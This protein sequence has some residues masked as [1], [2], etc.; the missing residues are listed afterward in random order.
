MKTYIT[1]A[2]LLLFGVANAQRY[3]YDDIYFDPVKDAVKVDPVEVEPA[4]PEATN[5]AVVAQ[6]NYATQNIGSVGTY[7]ERLQR[8]HLDAD[9]GLAIEGLS[10]YIGDSNYVNIFMLG[11]GSYNVS[12][13]GDQIDITPTDNYGS[14]YAWESSYGDSWWNR[15]FDAGYLWGSSRYWWNSY[16]Y[17]PFM[18]H[19]SYYHYGYYGHYGH[20]CGHW[21]NYYYPGYIPQSWWRHGYYGHHNGGHYYAHKNNTERDRRNVNSRN[22]GYTGGSTITRRGTTTTS[23][24]DGSTTTRGDG[25]TLARRNGAVSFEGTTTKV[26]TGDRVTTTG[27]GTGTT[28]TNKRRVDKTLP[29]IPVGHDAKIVR[30]NAD[31]RNAAQGNSST[32]SSTSNR[33]SS[34]STSTV[35]R[36]SS[37]VQRGNS[38]SNRG[39]SNATS[40][41]RGSSNNNKSKYIHPTST[42]S[43]KSS[44]SYQGT[45]STSRSTYR[46]TT[47]RT[48]GS[49]RSSGTV[50]SSGSTRSSGAVRSSGGGSRNVRR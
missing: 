38:T 37:T 16:Y 33:G 10:P 28:T 24:G 8:F 15:G 50:R 31:R 46:G 12:I 27:K 19:H 40:V 39:K 20:Y 22:S 23:R 5:L 2:M 34:V 47:T 4:A 14:N 11:E 18:H 32:S 44:T 35:R 3:D 7:T 43:R 29:A 26:L 49:T 6:T 21:N 45:S 41:R 48:S 13:Q 42:P 30:Q 36:G 17:H 25:S 1:L 9:N